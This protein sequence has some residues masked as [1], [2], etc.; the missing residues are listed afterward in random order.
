MA[1]PTSDDEIL[2]LHN[3]N[4]SKSRATLGLLEERGVTFETRHYLENPLGREELADLGQRLGRPALEFTRKGQSE[5]VDA[6]LDTSSSADEIF[7][8][9]VA[10]P[11]LLERP[12][13]IR[14]TRAA[15]GRP[16]EDV[17]QLLDP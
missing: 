8:A 9:M 2:L 13:L 5:F 16:P 3:P 4:C 7:T 10:S 15:I 11:I 17:L 1:L 12:I 6:G 14:G